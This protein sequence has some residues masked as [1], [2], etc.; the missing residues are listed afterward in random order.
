MS[1]CVCACFDC[2][3][4]FASIISIQSRRNL[5]IRNDSTPSGHSLVRL[6]VVSVMEA[7]KGFEA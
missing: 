6:S 7:T 3:L 5:S 2:S 4:V 1:V